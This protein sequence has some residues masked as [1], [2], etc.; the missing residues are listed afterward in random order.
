[1]WDY[2]A[3]TGVTTGFATAAT[4]ESLAARAIQ[5]ATFTAPHNKANLLVAI[6]P[7]QPRRFRAR[8]TFR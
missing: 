7:A 1:M 5:T 2:Y 3:Q 6:R 4:D 8:R